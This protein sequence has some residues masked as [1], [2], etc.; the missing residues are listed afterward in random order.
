M[1][2]GGERLRKSYW[3]ADGLNEDS[4]LCDIPKQ[5]S[6]MLLYCYYCGQVWITFQETG[7]KLA[8]LV[9]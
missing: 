8:V 7:D 3:E 1:K 9:F 5:M 6:N 4:K 2:M